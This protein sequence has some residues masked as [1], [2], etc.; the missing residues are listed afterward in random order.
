MMNIRS[1]M[2]MRY[3]R[4]R[5]DHFDHPYRQVGNVDE[6][7]GA[8]DPLEDAKLCNYCCR[9]FVVFVGHPNC[10]CSVESVRTGVIESAADIP[11]TKPLGFDDGV[12]INGGEWTRP[13]APATDEQ[14]PLPAPEDE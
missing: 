10:K 11:L 8:H 9:R 6:A 7:Y 1:K 4:W 3:R 14:R 2:K 13:T 12:L 5:C